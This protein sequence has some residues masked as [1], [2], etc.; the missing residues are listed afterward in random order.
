MLIISRIKNKAI[1]FHTAAKKLQQEAKSALEGTPL[2]KLQTAANHEMTTLVQT[3]DG[4]K[5]EAEKLDKATDSDIVKKYLAVA[6]Y[7]KALADKK[8]FTEAL[9]DPSSKDTVEKVTKKFDALQKSY[10]NVLKLRVQE[11]AKKSETLKNVADTLGTQVAEL[12]TQATQ[13]ATA[14]SNGSHGLKEKAADLVN[15]IKTDSQ[16]VTNAI[17]VIKQFEAVTDKYEEL[18]TAADSGGHKDKPA[19]KAVDT[20]YTDLNKHYDTILN[21]KK[22]TTLKGEVGNGSDDKILKKAKD[23]Y[24]KA[25]LLAGAPGLSSQPEDTQKAEL[26]KLAEALK[27]AVGASVAEG[28]QGALNQLKSATN[29]ALIVEKALEVIKHYGLVKDAY[30]A[31]KAKETQYTTALKGTGGKDETDKYTDVTSGFLALQFC[32]P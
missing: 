4:L 31:V 15:A 28:L 21:V 12:S 22:A 11:L 20:A 24:T 29:D 27:T 30:D 16:I 3:A 6:R 32:P 9:T 23:L 25:S 8:E 2:K 18:T 14:A 17:D 26:K 5:K 7:Y 13:L 19:V 1:A 10:E